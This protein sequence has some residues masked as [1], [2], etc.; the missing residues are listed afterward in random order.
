MR[1]EFTATQCSVEGEARDPRLPGGGGTAGRLFVGLSH[2]AKQGSQKD[3]GEGAIA[4]VPLLNVST[5]LYSGQV[6]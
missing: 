4:G 6:G 1:S 3:V 5:V 2:L